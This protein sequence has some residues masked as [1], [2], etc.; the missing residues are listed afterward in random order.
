M[1][2]NILHRLGKVVKRGHENTIE[3]LKANHQFQN[4][5]DAKYFEFDINSTLDHQI[6]V[7]HD[8][9]FR[10]LGI[11][12]KVRDMRLPE[13][14]KRWPW[15]PTL[16]EVL[17]ELEKV[18]KKPIRVEIKR[19]HSHYARSDALYFVSEYKKRTGQDIE[20]IA[21]P[22]HWRKSF[23]KSTRPKWEKEFLKKGM[24]V[25]SV[26]KKRKGMHIYDL[27]SKKYIDGKDSTSWWK[28]WEWF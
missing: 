24:H 8:R 20:F 3:R 23:P 10:K 6:I 18:A 2:S 16:E 19:L 21:F 11:K 22:S 25:L 14:R 1:S 5:K 15:I 9:D 7:F 27:F 26:K 4:R 17:D 13:I 28:F 12:A